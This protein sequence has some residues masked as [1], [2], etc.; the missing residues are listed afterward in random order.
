MKELCLKY[1]IVVY[2]KSE[3]IRQIVLGLDSQEKEP[4]FEGSP[5]TAA[6]L[7][8]APSLYP[9]VPPYLG[10]PLLQ[11]PAWVCSLVK[12]GEES[13]PTQIHKPFSLLQP[14]QIKQDLGA[15]QMTQANI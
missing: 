11:K 13:G 10:A 6:E 2:P 7:A 14:R 8:G 12:T 1:A 5:P 9:S 15:I 3:P 4:S